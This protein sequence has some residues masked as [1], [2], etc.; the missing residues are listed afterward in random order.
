MLKGKSITLRPV[1]ETD[2]DQL[3]RY[4][5]DIDNRGDFFPRGILAQPAFQKQFQETGFWSKDDGMLV[6]VSPADEILGHIE[7]FKTVNY[8][9]EYELSYQV[10]TLEQ[11]GKGVATEAVNLLVWYLFE[12]KRVNRI[13]LVIHPDNLASRRLAD[14]CGFRHEGTARGAWYHKGKHHEVEIYAILHDDV[15]VK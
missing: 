15:I 12:S 4:H 10:Y 9:D 5:V 1:R 14:K 7:F 11:R 8:L 13:R 2:L 6:M 3:Y